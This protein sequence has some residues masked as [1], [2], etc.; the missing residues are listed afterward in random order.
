MRLRSGTP[1]PHRAT[2]LPGGSDPIDWKALL[3]PARP[4]TD[5]FFPTF[6]AGAKAANYNRILASNTAALLAT[7][8]LSFGILPVW[9][10]LVIN[11]LTPIWTAAAVGPTNFWYDLID[12]NTRVQLAHTAD[13]LTAAIGV[14]PKTLNLISPYTVPAGVY[15]LYFGMMFAGTTPPTPI[16]TNG[17]QNG[18][19]GSLGSN[20]QLVGSL[21][22][23]MT[24]PVSDGT[25]LAA[26]SA[27]GGAV[28][29]C[30]I[31]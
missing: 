30:I 28:P 25:T 6:I 27:G 24:A 22:T 13:Q 3:G 12:V 10:G 11:G 5:P 2:H 16:L 15:A 1:S 14:G 23:G 26:F 7:G 21:N 29:Y 9:P 31:T 17:G 18:A 20:P 4:E 19:T 8:R